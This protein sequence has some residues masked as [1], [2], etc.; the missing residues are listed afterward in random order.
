[1]FLN[2]LR[3]QMQSVG[4]EFTS[5]SR[6]QI[7]PLNHENLESE[8]NAMKENEIT[9]AFFIHSD[10]DTQLHKA[11]KLLERKYE[12]VT[13]LVRLFNA[14]EIV[15]KGRKQMLANIVHKMNIKLGG[16]NHGLILECLP[17]EIND[18]VLC[19]GISVNHP[20][21]IN[22]THRTSVDN[23]PTIVGC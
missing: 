3:N 23:L 10:Q 13:Q 2:A 18:R 12:I 11:A 22:P 9:F 14:G 15:V 16:V 21:A 1:M 4:M 19:L 5:P 6:C 20:A 8:F 7:I 17:R